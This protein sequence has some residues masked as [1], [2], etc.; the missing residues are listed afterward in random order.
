MRRPGYSTGGSST[1]LRNRIDFQA[2]SC[3]IMYGRIC[4]ISIINVRYIT[5]E[6]KVFQKELELQSRGWIPTF[7]DV[8]KEVVEI[9]KAS[10][11]KNGTVCIAS[12]HT[13][14]SVM[15]QECSHEQNTS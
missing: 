14:C 6:F 8:S 13:T 3:Y 1:K 4:P 11:I 7:H 5:M 12:H 10:G 15:I 2:I 9:V